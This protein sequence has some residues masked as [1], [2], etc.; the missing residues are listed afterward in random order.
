MANIKLSEDHATIFEFGRLIRRR[1]RECVRPT[2]GQ[3]EAMH[4]IAREG[5]CSMRALAQYLQ[6]QAPSATSLADEMVRAGFVER[7]SGAKDRRSVRLQLTDA[8]EREFRRNLQIRQEVL[9]EM[10]G[11]LSE[12]ER[13]A[14]V[15][16]L[17]KIVTHNQ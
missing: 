13:G 5:S 10:L 11:S 1:M 12:A 9:G 14:F 6:V 17:R 15:A 2:I 4:F 7:V 16:I 8:G 3:L